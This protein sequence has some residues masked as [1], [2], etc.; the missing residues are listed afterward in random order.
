[1]KLDTEKAL[2]SYDYGQIPV[3]GSIFLLCGKANLELGYLIIAENLLHRCFQYK[4]DVQ[5]TLMAHDL[6]GKCYR[7]QGH[8]DQACDHYEKVIKSDDTTTEMVHASSFDLG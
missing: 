1:V 4:D 8:F 5:L 2:K 6:L 7:E 3:D